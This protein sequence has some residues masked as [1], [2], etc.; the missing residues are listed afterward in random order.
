MFSRVPPAEV[1]RLH[2]D[3]DSHTSVALAK[4]IWRQ[5][6]ERHL[7]VVPFVGE[8]DLKEDEAVLL[9]GDKVVNNTLIDHDIQTDLG[10]AWKSLTSLPFVFAVWAAPADIENAAALGVRLSA[11]RDAGVRS[12]E[13]I[14][15]DFGPGM[16]WPVTLAKRYLTTRLKFTLGPRQRLG[17]TK[18]FELTVRHGIVL[19]GRELVFA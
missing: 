17:M 1:H 6:Y 9:I 15:A 16:G 3:G 18:F 11:A 10:Q 13:M 14:A 12:A 2:V 8:E 19:D 7:E 5:V 4:V